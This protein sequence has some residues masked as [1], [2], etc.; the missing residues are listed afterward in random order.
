MSVNVFISICCFATLEAILDCF[1]LLILIILYVCKTINVSKSYK[2]R[3]LSLI[4]IDSTVR[5]LSAAY[6][7]AYQYY[8]VPQVLPSVC[9]DWISMFH[10]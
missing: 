8:L 2:L 6:K 5:Y 3:L 9:I 7:Y 1:Q 4:F 10:V